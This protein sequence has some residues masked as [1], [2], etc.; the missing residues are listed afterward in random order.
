MILVPNPMADN[1]LVSGRQGR[2]A[3]FRKEQEPFGGWT[4]WR[5][6]AIAAVT[7]LSALLAS[8][9][10]ESAGSTAPPV[11]LPS[12]SPAPA[13]TPAPPSTGDAVPMPA[14]A[15]A[16]EAAP[17]ANLYIIVGT[18]A[19]VVY[20]YQKGS[21]SPTAGV[22]I[23]SASKLLTSLVIQQL[24]ADG[25]LRLDDHPQRYL[26]YWTNSPTDPRS[27]VT[28]DQLLSMTSGFNSDTSGGGCISTAATTVQACARAIYDSGLNSAPGSSF[29]YG[30][31]AFQIAAAMAEAAT[32]KTINQI[33]NEELVT[34]FGLSG[35]GFYSPSLTNPMMA[36]GGFSTVEDYAKVMAAMLDG[37]LAANRAEFIRDRSAGLTVLYDPTANATTEWHYALGAWRECD[38]KPFSAGCTAQQ[39]VSSPGAFGWTP[40][41][42]YD[43]GYW[44]IIG[45]QAGFGGDVAS[46]RLEQQIQPLIHSAL[47]MP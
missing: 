46:V 25:T 8:C 39:L 32:G 22:P 13:P 23:A 14:V 44:A 34:P 5:G 30:G 12:P 42:D 11:S 29:S 21:F 2:L 47:G 4:R 31:T 15:A 26:S 10:G 37:R 20:R 40:W 6:S 41:I 33:V 9:G 7:M 28:L 27:R 1:C 36:G 24:V 35:T 18:R 3:A 45:I 19:G 17:V 16:A 38:Q 43:R